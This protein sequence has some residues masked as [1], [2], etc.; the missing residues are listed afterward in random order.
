MQVEFAIIQDTMAERMHGSSGHRS[1][2]LQP[3]F[4]GGVYL[5]SR[6]C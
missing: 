5:S 2:D 3:V 6:S 1:T 4:P